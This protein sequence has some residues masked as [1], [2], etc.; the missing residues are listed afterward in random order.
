ML[1]LYLV[2][3]VKLVDFIFENRIYL[4]GLVCCI[5]F[6]FLIIHLDFQKMSF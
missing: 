4:L 2:S 5:C 3:Y 6:I 1:D